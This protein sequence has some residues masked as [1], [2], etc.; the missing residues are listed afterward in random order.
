MT[1][2]IDVVFQLLIFFVVVIK[3]ED[4]FSKLSVARPASDRSPPT[5]PDIPTT[6]I[7]VSTQGFVFSGKPMSLD[8]LDRQLGRISAI[9]KTPTIV[10]KCTKD[11]QHGQLVQAL[12]LCSKHGLTKVSVFSM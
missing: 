12:D 6:E 7:V 4:I 10:V 11:S 9:S 5:T 3:Q 8:V 1:P 2:M